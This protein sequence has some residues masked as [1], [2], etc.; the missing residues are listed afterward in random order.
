MILIM[1]NC[2][3]FDLIVIFT[4]NIFYLSKFFSCSGIY[5]RNEERIYIKEMKRELSSFYP[6]C[7]SIVY[8]ENKNKTKKQ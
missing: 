8:T 6:N 3:N 1:N 2:I 4:Q 5:R 7:F